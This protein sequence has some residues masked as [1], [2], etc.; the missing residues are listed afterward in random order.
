MYHRDRVSLQSVIARLE[1][2]QHRPSVQKT[3]AVPHHVINAAKSQLLRA[4]AQI[5]DQS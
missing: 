3:P 1:A 5:E 2:W 4:L